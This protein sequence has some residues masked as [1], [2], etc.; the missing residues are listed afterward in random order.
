MRTPD[1]DPGM[2]R[3]NGLTAPPTTPEPRSTAVTPRASPARTVAR[4]ETTVLETTTTAL[5]IRTYETGDTATAED[6]SVL[7]TAARCAAGRGRSRRRRRLRRPGSPRGTRPCRPRARTGYSLRC[8]CLPRPGPPGR[9]PTP[10][11]PT[12]PDLLA[13]LR[14]HENAVRRSGSGGPVSL[15]RLLDLSLVPT[16]PSRA[17][18][19]ELRHRRRVP[20]HLSVDH[21]GDAVC[22]RD[23]GTP[24]ER[25]DVVPVEE[26]LGLHRGPVP[27]AMGTAGPL[28]GA[29]PARTWIGAVRGGSRE[30]SPGAGLSPT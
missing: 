20:G 28:N 25:L 23:P 9:G 24:A 6:G 4:S 30:P 12:G 5:P 29:R 21:R 7:L 18:I 15:D 1:I 10:S 26:I 19:W 16:L 17:V 8:P 11:S 13:R 14:R 2:T 27:A 3:A 22:L